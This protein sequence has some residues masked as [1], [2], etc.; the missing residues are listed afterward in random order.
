VVLGVAGAFSFKFSVN[1]QLSRPGHRFRTTPKRLTSVITTTSLSFSE[2]ASVSG[3][4]KMTTA[5]LDRLT[6][7]CHIL[8]TGNDSFRFKNSSAQQSKTRKEK[9]PSG[10]ANETRN[11]STSRV[12][13]GCPPAA[14]M[15]I[16]HPHNLGLNI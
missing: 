7:H 9:T 4:A 8:E 14:M 10:P 12:M 3:D 2:W 11:I 13:Y 5:L 16:L 1:R 15:T 6:Y